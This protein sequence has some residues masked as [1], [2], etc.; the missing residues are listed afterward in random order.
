VWL[1]RGY[2]PA[3]RSLKIR[4]FKLFLGLT[5]ASRSSDSHF[6]NLIK[7]LGGGVGR[8]RT[9]I[10]DVAAEN[11]SDKPIGTA[12]FFL[13]VYDKTKAR[14]GEGYLNLTNIAANQ[15]VK[16]QVTVSLSGSPDSLTVSRPATTTHTISI[17]VNSV[18]QGASF[19]VDGK[20]EGTTPKTVDV[21]VGTH[22]L[23][24]SKEGF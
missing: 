8:E 17:T 21:A 12:N 4:P 14:I 20:G 22:M 7:E 1:W 2:L 9:Y 10:T 5:Q 23:E 16:F 11:L 24:F 6:R 19:T 3:L 18:P 13:Y 15:T